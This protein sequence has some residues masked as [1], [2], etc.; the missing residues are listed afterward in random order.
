[1]QFIPLAEPKITKKDVTAVSSQLTSS[2]VGPGKTAEKFG[3]QLAR[4]TKRNY[5]IPTISGTV[6]LSIAAK[7][8]GLKPGDEILV[9][10]YGV[11]SVINA[12]K[13][14]GLKP[15]LVDINP[16]HG[17]IDTDTI[18]AALSPDT[19]AVCYI[20]FLGNIA[21]S[22]EETID[23]CRKNNLQIIEDAAW[24]LGRTTA[25]AC[26]ASGG[27]IAIT[28]FSVP[29]LITTG[30]GGALFTN[31]EETQKNSIRLIDQGGINWRKTGD[32]ELPGSNLRMSDINAALGLSQLHSL[33]K[34]M[35]R[36]Q[37]IFNTINSILEGNLVQPE[38]GLF[39]AQNVI[40]VHDR[41]RVLSEIKKLNIGAASNY[42]CIYNLTPYVNLKQGCFIGAEFWAKHALYLPFGIG[43]SKRDMKKMAQ[44][45][46]T[47]PIDFVDTVD[48]ERV[49]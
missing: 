20:S 29:K 13:T 6:A 18:R 15:G 10:A 12:F 34:R 24:S 43:T 3:D 39:P 32:I 49:R 11:V 1:M 48:M 47:L 37:Q 42:G 14:V 45:V 9:P 38:D 31:D 36:K 30:Q 23:F 46:M 41:D 26:G 28:S 7:A 4:L 5:A 44:A 35:N 19:K 2:F 22:Y 33:P 21:G 40:L 27:D 16:H 17:C 8:I 25:R